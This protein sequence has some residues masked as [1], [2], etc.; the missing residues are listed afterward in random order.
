MSIDLA[1]AAKA[2]SIKYFLI[3]YT[4]LFGNQRAK[5]VPA[6]AIGGMQKAGAGFAGF[7]TWLDMTPA[8]PDL[9]AMPDPDSLIQLPWKP[10]V[11]WL[12]ADLWMDGKP[13][14]HAPR[15]TLKRE[16]AKA[17][18]LGYQM[19]T[20]VECEFFLITPDG[21][22]IAD[23]ADSQSK[24]CYDQQAL[25][26]RYDV[27]TEI[28]DAMLSLGWQPYQNDHEDANGQF[29]MNWHYDDALVTADRQA[30][31][32]FMVKSIAETH[33]LRATFMPKPFS[34][35]TGNGCHMH[36]SL[37]K[38]SENAFEDASASQGLSS[39][40]LAFIGGI[41]HSADALAAF[42]NPTVNSYKRINAP[43][44][45]SGATWAPNS[46]TWTGNNRTHMIRVPEGDRFELRLADGATNPYLMPAAVLAAGLDGIT[47]G[48][49]P[50]KRL[51]INMYTD[52][53]LVG[54]VKKLPLNL[55][56]ALRALEASDVMTAALGK[57]VPAYLKLKQGEW[58]EYAA[59]LTDWERANTLDC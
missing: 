13:V 43:R 39:V 17:A 44:T 57:T 52:G 31:F 53:H 48:R 21:T 2:K 51:D 47:Q 45:A 7:A 59:H 22:A 3:S 9:F 46:V 33:G 50:G 55:L 27:I 49:D 12:A 5:L 38:G 56:D 23:T 26:R 18:S 41:I 58:N 36:V 19:K 28:C 35:L 15:N 24:P 40:G 30:F 8:D 29:E 54:D 10:E 42:L 32:K 37:W 14:E 1:E 6:S 4:D 34:K 20:G 16:I 25:M 11:G